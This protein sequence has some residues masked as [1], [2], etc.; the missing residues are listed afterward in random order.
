MATM[1]ESLLMQAETMAEVSREMPA[2]VK[3]AVEMVGSNF[4]KIYIIGSGTSLNAAKTAL[5]AF[6]HY[7]AAEVRTVA[8][9]DFLH[10]FPLG[11]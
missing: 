1:K 2:E 4:S 5:Y 6:E 8:P 9:F 3:R 10:Y 11:V 7:T